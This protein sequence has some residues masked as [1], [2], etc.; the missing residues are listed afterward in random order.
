MAGALKKNTQRKTINLME[1]CGTHTMSI[2]RNGLKPLFPAGV[3]MLTGPGCPIC[4]TETGDIDR[5]I[6]LSR[7]QG[8]IIA[9]FG[10]MLRV[11]GSGSSLERERSAGAD[12]RIVYSPV[13]ALS[14]AR[15]N[16]SKEVVF[17]GVGFETT[18][19]AV[20]AT[21]V[22]ARR[23]R[24]RNFSVLPLFKTVPEALRFLLTEGKRS[25]GPSIDGFL[26]PGHVSSIIGSGPYH[27]IA[28]EF[29]V[30]GVIAGFEPDDIL[31]SVDMLVDM[32]HRGSPAIG[33]QYTR[34][35]PE[36]GNPVARKLLKKVFSPFDARW[37]SIGKIRGSGLTF[38][39]NFSEFDASTRFSLHVPASAEPKGCQCGNILLGKTDPGRCVLF[40][41]KCTPARPIGPCMVS[42]EGA[43]AA[44]YKYGSMR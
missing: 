40:G 36:C 44:E 43:C 39:R 3:R 29:G 31:R 18:S 38:N 32:V 41:K 4:V 19:P 12:I 11:P 25:G 5:A 8:V 2:A 33:I 30:P 26:L 28:E 37:R 17:I 1:V 14:I 22:M 20:A 23:G 42:S 7:Q 16:R 24:I 6:M 15:E 9:T 10:D 21:V 34:S 13:D 35:V 27:F